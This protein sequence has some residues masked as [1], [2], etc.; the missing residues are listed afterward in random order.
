VLETALARFERG[1]GRRLSDS[2]T[3][4]LTSITIANGERSGRPK[5]LPAGSHAGN[6]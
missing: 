2:I 3:L 6:P 4:F 5:K 1:K